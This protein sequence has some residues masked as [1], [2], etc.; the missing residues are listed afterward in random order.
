MLKRKSNQ[1]EPSEEQIERETLA[2]RNRESF[3]GE[4]QIVTKLERDRQVLFKLKTNIAALE[5]KKIMS[6]GT[7]TDFLEEKLRK[8]KAIYK[9]S[10]ERYQTSQALYKYGDRNYGSYASL[11]QRKNIQMVRG[12]K[13]SSIL[14]GFSVNYVYS[15]VPRSFFELDFQLQPSPGWNMPAKFSETY[16]N[17]LNGKTAEF[18]FPMHLNEKLLPKYNMQYA[19]NPDDASDSTVEFINENL[20]ILPKTPF[21]FAPALQKLY[22][23]Y[24]T[25]T[26]NFKDV[27]DIPVYFILAATLSDMHWT[28][29][30]KKMSRAVF[31]VLAVL[32]YKGQ[33]YSIGY[34]Y[35]IDEKTSAMYSPD[36]VFNIKEKAHKYIVVDMGILQLI[37][38]QRMNKYLQGTTDLI[39]W[40]EVSKFYVPG[41]P[42][43]R[44][45][46]KSQRKDFE[47]IYSATL[48]Q[49]NL[50]PGFT[51]IKL[52]DPEI[53]FADR[54]NR[55]YSITTCSNPFRS[56]NRS[57]IDS[58]KRN[59]TQ[60]LVDVFFEQITCSSLLFINNPGFFSSNCRKRNNKTITTENLNQ[61]IDYYRTNSVRQLKG[62]LD[63][64]AE[65]EQELPLI[66]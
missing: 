56:E 26:S 34:G 23:S 55:G 50:K 13:L 4:K 58:G 41:R 64:L 31:H 5:E 22:E 3:R 11:P 14:L 15:G 9:A 38:L 66:G 47:D 65:P 59:C 12:S 57:N 51:Y 25:K 18:Y 60:F 53:Y 32:L 40:F 36:P 46:S 28:Q 16:K 63:Y 61:F 62:L 30:L 24:G 27:S 52:T 48:Q 1:L 7:W 17:F 42:N 33:T 37:H 45:S 49:Q 35:A 44:F 10:K 8:L 29:R 19:T 6:H 20:K 43:T 39:P 54:K 21:K 2:K